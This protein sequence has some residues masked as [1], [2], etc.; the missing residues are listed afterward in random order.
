LTSLAQAPARN[1]YLR[2]TEVVVLAAGAGRRLGT[3]PK[4]LLRVA[5]GRSFLEVIADCAQQG[6]ASGVVAVLGPPHAAAIELALPAGVR[7]VMNL[8]PERGMLSSVQA[9]IAALAPAVE[10]ALV[11]PVDLPY[12]K[13]ETV[14][15]LLA[16]APDKLVLPQHDGRG[17][18]PLRIPRSCFAELAALDPALGLR[19]LMA[20]RPDRVVCLN[21]DDP[22]VLLDIDTPGDLRPG[23]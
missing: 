7:A 5:D 9:G 14:R 20:A 10:A 8:Q 21:V 13:P 1:W 22:G 23:P 6:G 3:V 11:W 16:G 19:G 4:A 15:A 18:H 2:L 12:V 17:G